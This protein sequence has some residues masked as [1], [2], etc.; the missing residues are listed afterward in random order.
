MEKIQNLMQIIVLSGNNSGSSFFLRFLHS[1]LNDFIKVI[2]N[3][4]THFKSTIQWFFFCKF[5]PI[6]TTITAI[7]SQNISITPSSIL[8]V[9]LQL[10][11]ITSPALGNH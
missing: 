2:Y 6:C 11:P 4:F 7:Q 8:P 10:I 9:S 3:K 1:F 5:K